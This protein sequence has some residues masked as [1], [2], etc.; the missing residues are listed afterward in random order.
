MIA[1]LSPGAP[2]TPLAV[3]VVHRRDL[4]PLDLKLSKPV[5]GQRR[6]CRPTNQY[7]K[8]CIIT[9]P[10][11]WTS[12]GHYASAADFR[13]ERRLMNVHLRL[14]DE[15]IFS[16]R[17]HRRS[18][19]TVDPPGLERTGERS[20]RRGAEGLQ[21]YLNM[22]R[23]LDIA[24]AGQWFDFQPMIRRMNRMSRLRTD[25]FGV[26]YRRYRFERSDTLYD[27]PERFRLAL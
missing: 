2:V 23:S 11:Q 27:I 6:F 10:V 14:M 20:W 25:R 5:L 24:E 7:M 22:M 4:E 19:D 15:D 12:G 18:T 13:I 17:A 1:S 21:E 3:D 16:R 26:T 8:P 9:D